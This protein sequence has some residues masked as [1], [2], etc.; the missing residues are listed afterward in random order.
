M[1]RLS[2][3]LTISHS[4]AD[5][6]IGRFVSWFSSL[7]ARSSLLAQLGIEL[8]PQ[9]L[10]ALLTFLANQAKRAPPTSVH[11]IF[12]HHHIDT[13]TLEAR[14]TGAS[15]SKAGVRQFGWTNVGVVI[16]GTVHALS[17]IIE[18]LHQSFYYYL[19]PATDLYVSIGS[20]VI[21]LALI[22]LSLPLHY[23]RHLALCTES[24]AYDGT[25]LAVALVVISI[26][27]YGVLCSLLPSHPFLQLSELIPAHLV[28]TVL[29]TAVGLLLLL[30]A[31]LSLPPSPIRKSEVI[32]VAG[33]PLILSLIACTLVNFSLALFWIAITVSFLVLPAFLL[34]DS[35][36]LLSFSI[37]LV[38]ANPIS[39]VHLCGE[40]PLLFNLYLPFWLSS[41]LGF[42]F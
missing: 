33:I 24:S 21:P 37:A 23:L 22:G 34:Q 12:N 14:L 10:N 26:F 15:Q 11:S 31:R 27:G 32:M 16:E 40:M 6:N 42:L 39:I 41:L 7:F 30:V 20:Y 28:N 38:F 5:S 19:L 29:A 4:Q 2:T 18:H 17:N 9:H 13:V 36:S 1:S 3:G 25:T 8:V 35:A